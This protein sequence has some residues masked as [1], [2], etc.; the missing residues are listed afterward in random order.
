MANYLHLKN[1][2]STRTALLIGATGL[3]GE[4]VL[5][6][7]LNSAI[8]SKVIAVVRKPL[9]L[10]HPKL[11]SLVVDFDNL[12]KYKAQI[13]ADDVY[14]A[15]GTTIAK[16]GSKEAF[17]KV[18]YEYPLQIAK[19][20][21]WNGARRFILVSSA[22][23]DAKSVIFYSK[24]KGELEEALKLLKYEALIIF[25]PSILLGDR[26]E[27]RTGEAI[28][29]FVAEKLSFLFAG[30]LKAYKGTPV[31]ILAAQM[32]KLGTGSTKGV[33]IVEN[34]EIF[35]LAEKN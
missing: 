9:S 33:R 1:N 35:E 20:A 25:R 11:E 34:A 26:K 16:A 7:L 23:A 19:I 31:D 15:I 3:T 5:H 2:M 27:Q 13:R 18:D 10:H 22:G 30:P 28:G 17:T 24:T 4:Q 8:Y 29:Q 12:D 14:C 32:V 21:L 6:E